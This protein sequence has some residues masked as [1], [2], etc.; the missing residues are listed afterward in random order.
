M[1][2]LILNGSPRPHG[3]TKTA[4]N[5]VAQGIQRNI[6]AA[7]INV[8]DVAKHKLMGCIHCNKCKTNGGNCVLPDETAA[9]LQ[10]VANADV[11]IFASP[12]Y[13]WGVTS[14]L[15]TVID[16][17][18]SKA[19]ELCAAPR[20]F[21]TIIIGGALITDPQYNVIQGQFDCMSAYTGW[22]YAFAECA[23][24]YEKDDLAKDH[25]T[26]AL[27]QDVWKKI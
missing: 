1:N 15:K 19:E 21:G 13:S 5:I 3:N 10:Q 25:A 6:P 22:K 26:L 12:V 9:I 4:V 24:A 16:K 11:V 18:Y 2:I 8:V 20:I 7:A 17:L 14:Q 27:L 23:C